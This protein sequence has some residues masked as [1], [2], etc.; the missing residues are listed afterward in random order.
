G[1]ASLSA[2]GLTINS[3]EGNG[4]A[5]AVAT[6]TDA[7]VNAVAADFTAAISWGDGGS[8]LGT[9]TAIGGGLFT[10]TGNYTY[11][12]EGNYSISVFITDVGGAS[13]SAASNAG[14]GDALLSAN[15]VNINALE[16]DA[17]TGVVATFTDTNANGTATDFQASIDW[18]DGTT[19]SATIQ[20]DANAGF[21]VIG[22]HTYALAGN[23]AIGVLIQ[24]IGGALAQVD[25]QAVVAPPELQIVAPSTNTAGSSFSIT[26]TAQ[27]AAHNT[28]TGYTGTIHFA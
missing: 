23:Y 1:D 10:I 27:D 2:S 14:V 16:E 28:L 7:N 9:V 6:F 22:S 26:V 4:F 8:S 12:E 15:G 19:G 20:V 25:S 13:I 21:D 11:A 18:G 3:L 5:G 24:D 17:F